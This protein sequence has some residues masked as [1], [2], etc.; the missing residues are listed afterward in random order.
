MPNGPVTATVASCSASTT[1]ETRSAPGSTDVSSS[2]TTGDEA[3]RIP[4]FSAAAYPSRTL[5]RRTSSVTP[6]TGR[7]AASRAA[8]AEACAG[9]AR[10]VHDDDL[11]AG[12]RRRCQGPNGPGQVVRPVRGEEHHRGRPRRGLVEPGRNAGAGSEPDHVAILDVRGCGTDEVV[13][14]PDVDHLPAGRRNPGEERIGARPVPVAARGG[15]G[16]GQLDDVVGGG[17]VGHA[18]EDTAG[19]RAVRRLS[20]A[21]L[22]H[23]SAPRP[24]RRRGR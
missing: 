14:G 11:G 16:V 3:R 10:V 19:R 17:F 9:D 20:A 13:Q 24:R 7:P 2:S 6:G 1:A 15:A 22:R 23:P 18:L 4:A 12:R 5:V 21:R 8:S